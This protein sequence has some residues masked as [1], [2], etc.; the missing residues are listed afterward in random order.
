MSNYPDETIVRTALAHGH[1]IDITTTGRVS[2]RPHRTE[3]VFHNFDGHIYIS[4][5]PG[6][7]RDWYRNLV[8][9][10]S[11]TFHLKGVVSADLPATAWPIEDEPRRRAVFEKIVTVWTSMDPKHMLAS[12]PLVEVT[13]PGLAVAA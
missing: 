4:G 7:V 13:F 11:F 9:D 1:T 3:I 6:R 12:S 10:P 2:G 8:T 5:R